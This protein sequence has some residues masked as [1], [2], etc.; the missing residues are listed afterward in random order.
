MSEEERVAA[1]LTDS[2]TGLA[3]DR[4]YQEAP[5]RM[6]TQVFADLEGLKWVNDQWTHEAGDAYLCAAA[7][8][9]RVVAEIYGGRVYRVNGAGDEFLLEFASEDDA[10]QALK[11][12]R[13]HLDRKIWRFRDVEKEHARRGVGISFG[14]GATLPAAEA[15]YLR[16]KAQEISLGQR[17]GRGDR[18]LAVREVAAYEVDVAG[19]VI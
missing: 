2:L 7:D 1:L 3:N 18:P 11:M 13:L 19:G 14:V 17:A 9:L 10:R 15:D 12:A 8:T 5:E 4:A 16:A 6:P